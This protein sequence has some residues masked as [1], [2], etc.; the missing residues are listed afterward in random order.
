MESLDYYQ[1]L[2]VN[3]EADEVEIK[4]AYLRL[5]RQYHPDKN[6]N[7]PQAEE[8]F[9]AI[10]EA[11]D[12]LHSE[13]KR[14]RYDKYGKE[15]LEP[16]LGVHL[17][18]LFS[19]L[20]GAGKFD[21]CFGELSL[22][23]MEDRASNPTTDQQ[24]SIEEHYRETLL[25]AQLI[26]KIDDFVQGR[27]EVF[28]QKLQQDISEKLEAPGGPSLLFQLGYIYQQEAKKHMGRFFGVESFVARIQETTHMVSQTYK[29]ASAAVHL[30]AEVQQFENQMIKNPEMYVDHVPQ[31]IY[32]K[33]IETLWR[34]G[35]LEIEGTVRAI[36]QRV[37]QDQS[38]NKDIRKKRAVA[39]RRLGELYRKAGK[40]VL[41]T[42]PNKNKSSHTYETIFSE[43]TQTKPTTASSTSNPLPES[44]VPRQTP[45]TTTTTTTTTSTTSTFEGV[46]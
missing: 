27:H 20:F 34:M 30:Q 25:V 11:Y 16:E 2:E 41:K 22:F 12:V 42:L 15:G 29:F 23:S 1:I 24:R 9:K 21:E 5:A 17:E 3:R 26:E 35:K 6:P 37:L 14:Q 46:D 44:R 36:C 4:R 33:G 40:Q 18:K 19:S 39:I 28:E 8:K 31:R 38:V 43:T 45:A 7:D 10:T 32:D 13:D